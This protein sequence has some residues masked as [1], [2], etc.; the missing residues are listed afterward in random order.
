MQSNYQGAPCPGTLQPPAT[1]LGAYATVNYQEGC[2]IADP[3]TNGFQA[4]ITAAQ[5]ADAT[6]IIAGLDLSQEAEGKDRTII[7]WPGV[8]Q[9]LIAQV[10]AA[11]KGP[12]VLVIMAGE[13]NDVTS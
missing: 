13:C 12:V 4:A 7:S 11:S 2:K 9:Q 6:V 10:T 8:Q 3:S 1:T 5:A